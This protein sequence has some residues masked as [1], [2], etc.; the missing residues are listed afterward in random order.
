MLGLM[1]DLPLVIPGRSS[2]AEKFNRHVSIKQLPL[3]ATGKVQKNQLP[4]Q[5]KDCALAGG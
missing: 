2:Q 4:Q 1:Q 3:G 5:F